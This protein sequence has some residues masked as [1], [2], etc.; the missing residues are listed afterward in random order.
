M[1]YKE[2]I[3]D[4]IDTRGQW[5]ISDNEYFEVHHIIPVCLGGKPS[6]EQCTPSVKFSQHPNLIWLYPKEHYIAH[7]LLFEENPDCYGLYA[8]WLGTTANYTISEIEYA[9][10]REYAH[11]FPKHLLDSQPQEDFHYKKLKVAERKTNRN[12]SKYK[13][14]QA[15]KRAAGIC[16][17]RGK[18]NGMYGNGHLIS[19]GR[20]GHASIRY[21][22][23]D[24]SFESRKELLEY[25]SSIN[26]IITASAIRTVVHKKGTRRVYNMYRDV[27]DNLRWEYKE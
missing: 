25:L 21:F 26:V 24:K 2:F 22:Y 17:T 20:N 27:F 15:Y 6:H 13:A 1:T 9:Q 14:Y 11:S 10:L 4:I 18:N 3:E 23:K 7:K 5:N 12:T 8:A 19:G 16:E